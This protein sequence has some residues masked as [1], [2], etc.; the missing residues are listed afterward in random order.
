MKEAQAGPPGNG[1]ITLLGTPMKMT[2][3]AHLVL[4]LSTHVSSWEWRKLFWP[5]LEFSMQNLPA[6]SSHRP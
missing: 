4:L 1:V 2:K 3:D 6:I 5:F